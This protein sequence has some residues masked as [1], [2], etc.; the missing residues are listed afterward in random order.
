EKPIYVGID[1]RATLAERGQRNASKR[2]HTNGDKNNIDVS[3]SGT[4]NHR[5]RSR[6][7]RQHKHQDSNDSSTSKVNHQSNKMSDPS[8]T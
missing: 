6:T 8:Q 4:S 1:H 7:H 5:T 3:N 2:Q